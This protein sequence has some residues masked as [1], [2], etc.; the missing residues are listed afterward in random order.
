MLEGGMLWLVVADGRRARVWTQARRGDH[1]EARADLAMHL[2]PEDAYDPQDRPPRTHESVGG[3]RHAMDGGHSLHEREEHNFLRRLAD[4]INDGAKHERFEHL[5][6]SAPPR[7]LGA[8][9]SLLSDAASAL[10]R[11]DLDKDVVDEDAAALHARLI[12]LLRSA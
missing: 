10:L 9:R 5:V 3:A 1:L 4:R 8:L 6:I 2:G 12:D 7:A 11:A